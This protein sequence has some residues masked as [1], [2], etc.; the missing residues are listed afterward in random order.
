[1][2]PVSKAA[3]IHYNEAQVYFQEDHNIDIYK[4]ICM[5]DLYLLIR[6]ENIFILLKIRKRNTVLILAQPKILIKLMSGNVQDKKKIL[7]SLSV[8]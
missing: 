1:M 5:Y 3:G 8:I 2:Q 7:R 4:K 6:L